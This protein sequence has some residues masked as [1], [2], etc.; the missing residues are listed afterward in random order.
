M[1][2]ADWSAKRGL[3]TQLFFSFCPI[4]WG[5]IFDQHGRSATILCLPD[6]LHHQNVYLLKLS[7]RNH[8]HMRSIQLLG[9]Q[10]YT[11]CICIYIYISFHI[12]NKIKQCLGKRTKRPLSKVQQ[13]VESIISASNKPAIKKSGIM[14][15]QKHQNIKSRAREIPALKGSLVFLLGRSHNTDWGKSSL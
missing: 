9:L 12:P 14:N 2:A 7:L 4:I 1:G 13:R 11:H 6:R 15:Q 3:A 8:N 5:S 10:A